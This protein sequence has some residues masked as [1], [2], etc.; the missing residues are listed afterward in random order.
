MLR[1]LLNLRDPDSCVHRPYTMYFKHAKGLRVTA[2]MRR[3]LY[4]LDITTNYFWKNI[5]YYRWKRDS[6]I[7]SNKR[8]EKLIFFF[9]NFVLLPSFMLL[10]G[11]V[12]LVATFNRRIQLSFLE[13]FVSMVCVLYNLFVMA[14]LST[15]EGIVRDATTGWK[16]LHELYKSIVGKLVK[17]TS[18]HGVDYVG[19]L[20]VVIVLVFLWGPYIVI[21]LLVTAGV[22]TPLNILLHFAHPNMSHGV[23][24]MIKLCL[25]FPA[26]EISRDFALIL[27]STTYA[28]IV[29]VSML[30][31]VRADAVEAVG[32]RHIERVRMN[33]RKLEILC[34]VFATYLRSVSFLLQSTAFI[35]L[36]GANFIS[37][38]FTF[39][40]RWA[41]GGV[42]PLFWVF[43]AITTVTLMTLAAK[44]YV[45]SSQVKEILKERANNCLS[46]KALLREVKA[47]SPIKIYSGKSY[48]FFFF[49]PGT[50]VTFFERLAEYC[51]TFILSGDEIF[52]KVFHIK[53]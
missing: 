30:C 14:L 44:P 11:G 47:L 20:L 39:L 41:H 52:W 7:V 18:Y 9:V 36:V 40:P 3:S 15:A 5:V 33:Y 25:L 35:V 45:F 28:G 6:V 34:G 29:W 17:N 24:L 50:T 8:S 13:L 42:V 12:L 43:V 23:H 21:F 38:K 53:L 16:A 26:M 19:I 27:V 10:P 32:E 31:R 37:V 4:F 51:V 22:P 49:K 1:N 48:N 46:R 2:L